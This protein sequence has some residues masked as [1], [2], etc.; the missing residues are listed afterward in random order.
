MRGHIK[1]RSPGHWAIVLDHHDAGGKRRR[2]WRSFKG[3]KREAQ[4]ECARLIA[5]QQRGGSVDPNKISVDDYLTSFE[6]DWCSLHLTPASAERY[7]LALTHVKR[8]LGGRQLQKLRPAD[9]IAMYA[10]LVRGG[11]NPKT[12]RLTH[13]VLHRALGEAKTMGS[14]ASNPADGVKPP[15]VVDRKIEVLQPDQARELLKRLKGKLPLY[16]IASLGLST[17][18]RRNE[19]LALTWDCVDLD[20]G[21]I[22]VKRALEGNRPN[23]RVKEPKSRHGARVIT[24]P[25]GTVDELREHRLAQQEARFAAG[26]G[27]LPADAYV[28]SKVDG[29]ALSPSAITNDW[30]RVMRAIGMPAITLHSLRHTHASTL[31]AGGVDVL[32][33]SRRLGHSKPSITLDVYAHLLSGADDRAADIMGAAL[34]GVPAK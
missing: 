25:R 21:K 14:I 23:A 9:I 27:R 1:E 7:G 4:T 33:V 18:M 16:L 28:F 31:L 5:E 11:L 19:M 24:L 26:L 32:T 29:S 2:V 3:T 8:H 15:K 10:A 34:T 13:S 6:T 30:P 17:G 12:V 22:S 20:A